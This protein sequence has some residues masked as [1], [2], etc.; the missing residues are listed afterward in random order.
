MR[1]RRV[2]LDGGAQVGLDRRAQVDVRIV[3]EILD[4][5][6][7]PVLC[8]ETQPVDQ[9]FKLAVFDAVTNDVFDF[10]VA[11]IMLSSLY[12]R[13]YD[14]QLGVRKHADSGDVDGDDVAVRLAQEADPSDER[15][16]D[17]HD[18]VWRMGLAI[19]A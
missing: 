5:L 7:G 3:E 12:E 15:R 1:E 16:G 8:G 18:L 9:Q 19:G 11:R 10:K 2:A 17:I 13:V 4:W 6:V 14:M